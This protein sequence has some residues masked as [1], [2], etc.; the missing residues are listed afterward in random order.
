MSVQVPLVSGGGSQLHMWQAQDI[1]PQQKVSERKGADEANTVRL[2]TSVVSMVLR[3][4]CAKSTRR[5]TA[6]K[7]PEINERENSDWLKIKETT[8]VPELLPTS[9]ES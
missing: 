5:P 1:F 2:H 7:L 9:Q 3:L 6:E 8:T 4:T